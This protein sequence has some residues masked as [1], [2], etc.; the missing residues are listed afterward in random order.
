MMSKITFISIGFFL[1]ASIVGIYLLISYTYYLMT[2]S[3]RPGV[4]PN[5]LRVHVIPFHLYFISLRVDPTHPH[6]E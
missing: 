2:L 5:F 1:G 3:L 4:S 6:E